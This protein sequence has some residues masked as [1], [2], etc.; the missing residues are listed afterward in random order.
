MFS[1][2]ASVCIKHNIQVLTEF[3]LEIRE[4]NISCH[5]LLQGCFV[6]SRGTCFINVNL[7]LDSV[8]HYWC[9]WL[10]NSITALIA[11]LTTCKHFAQFNFSSN[12]EAK[13]QSKLTTS[14]NYLTQMNEIKNQQ[15]CLKSYIENIELTQEV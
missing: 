10:I 5:M 9:A 13:F 12:T 6:F 7:P 3:A 2:F 8:F 4:S 1:S 11:S 14:S 15:I